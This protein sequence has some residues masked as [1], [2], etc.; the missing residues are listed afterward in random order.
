[1]SVSLRNDPGRRIGRIALVLAGTAALGPGTATAVVPVTMPTGSA[2]TA[3]APPPRLTATLPGKL[4]S[5]LAA[6]D[7]GIVISDTLIPARD[8]VLLHARIWRPDAPAA[9]RPAI[10]TLT[11]YTAD[12]AQEYASY[13][14]RHGY[15]YVNVDVR[16]RGGSEGVF[17]PLAQDGPDGADAVGWIVR[18]PWSDGR[19][20]MRGGSYRGMTQWQT[21]AQHPAGL[22]TVLPT[23]S[24]YPGWDYPNPGGIFMSYM[25]QWLAFVQGRASQEQLFDDETYWQARFRVMYDDG[26]PYKDLSAIT[27][28]PSRVFDQWI[29][30]PGFDAY[31][32]AMSPDSAAYHA[33][34]IP[35][36]TITGDFDGDQDGA[37][38]YYRE[39]MRYCTPAAKA[40]H[41]LVIGPWNHPG[42]RHPRKELGGLTFTDTA[43]IDMNR[44]H[45]QWFDHVFRGAPLPRFL[46]D[47]V[48]YYVMGEGVWK[49][50]PSLDAVADTTRAWY[51]RPG[52]G[53]SADVFHSGTLAPAG[54]LAASTPAG[55]RA[56]AD[57]FHYDPRTRLST[58]QLQQGGEGFDSPGAA[59][60]PGPKLIYQSPPLDRAI[61]V[62]GWMHL[63]VWLSMTVP[64][65]D[66]A[67]V[68]YEVTPDGGTIYLGDSELRA[69]Y[70][71]G[72]DQPPR[73]VQPGTVERYRFDRFHW[74][75]RRLEKGSRLRLVML[76][77]NTPEWEKNYQT[78]GD[79]ATEALDQARSGTL[80]LYAGRDH[81]SA[82]VVP[83]R[84]AAAGGG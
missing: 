36:L 62:S 49:T 82:L 77:V 26:R 3:S 43:A 40:E 15:V 73:L 38:R 27:G 22:K 11:P 66:L 45:L 60:A 50:A 28:A 47:R 67:A 46:A 68:V 34:D 64:D 16:G 29:Q 35:I 39:A 12:D 59:F 2:A 57:S 37:L 75:S 78:S 54:P 79:P 51:L 83:V 10:L 30:H 32:R 13:L 76:P 55:A 69:R 7:T 31:W 24:V 48:V 6:A 53:G 71:R 81:P 5:R 21:L 1:V 19:V 42:T 58:E 17:W 61:E 52:P 25:A 72:V 41:Y 18:Q 70:R 84:E 4:T 20:G 23:A 8:G 80:R 65:M 33:I 74:F 56:A 14:A 9:R 63:D 44:L